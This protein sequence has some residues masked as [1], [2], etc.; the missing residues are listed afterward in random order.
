[1]YRRASTAATARAVCALLIAALSCSFPPTSPTA[2]EFYVSIQGD[3]LTGNG[4]QAKPWRH[5]QYAIEHLPA[6]G[7]G[8]TPRINLAKGIYN[9]DLLIHKALTLRGAG[10]GAVSTLPG[11]PLTP[12]AEI[13]VIARQGPSDAPG[14]LIEAA[15]SVTLDSLVVFG[16]GLRAVETRLIMRNVEV[17]ASVGLYGVQL[18]R[19]PLFYIED[20]RILTSLSHSDFGLHIIDSSGEINTS[21]IGDLFDHVIEINPYSATGDNPKPPGV[22]VREVTLAGSNV[23]WADGIRVLGAAF[24]QVENTHITRTHPDN[25]APIFV[26]NQFPY[27]GIEVRGSTPGGNSL[28]AHI[29]NVTIGGFDTGIAVMQEGG[30]GLKVQNSSIAADTYDVWMSYQGYQIPPGIDFGGGQHGSA[31]KNFFDPGAQYGFHND[32][33]YDVDACYNNWGVAAAKIDAERIYDEL[34]NSANGRV[35]WNCPQADIIGL[36]GTPTLQR[37]AAT[38][39]ASARPN[40]WTAVVLQADL[41]YEG[42]GADFEVVSALRSGDSVEVL[43]LGEGRGYFVVRNP[44]YYDP[45]WVRVT[46]LDFPGA[47]DSLRIFPA[48]TQP[49][50]VVTPTATPAR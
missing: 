45:C 50:A 44:I 40:H 41:C 35:H 33:P 16:G 4:T 42:P 1:M 3:D 30:Y 9:E 32:V 43:G 29:D 37:A 13:S 2:V 34:D 18:E 36:P 25:E 7:P 21:Y 22:T 49:G 12:I 27:A 17:Q 47:I 31:G 23:F 5:I 11:D 6:L 20:S 39:D 46:A 15:D 19:S 8:Q 38:P 48:P 10:V 28:V 14:I 26:G 24:L